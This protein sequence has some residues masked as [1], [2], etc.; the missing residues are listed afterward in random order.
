MS[1]SSESS[2]EISRKRKRKISSWYVHVYI[3][4]DNKTM[5]LNVV[6]TIKQKMA[7][8]IFEAFDQ[9]ITQG[10]K[11]IVIY[12]TSGGG[13]SDAGF[14]IYNQIKV[15][16]KELDIVVIGQ[17]QIASSAIDIL[18]ASDKRYCTSDCDILVHGISYS[19]KNVEKLWNEK[20]IRLFGKRTKRDHK[21]WHDRMLTGDHNYTPKEAKHIGLVHNIIELKK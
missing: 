8:K 13:H 6:G 14:A 4:D 9:A 15:Y 21:Y 17:G 11:R 16:K 12:V 7:N 5:T 1:D 2:T 20:M 19:S 3:N 10:L 18:L